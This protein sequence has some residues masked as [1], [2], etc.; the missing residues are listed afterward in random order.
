MIHRTRLPTTALA[1]LLA[2]ATLHLVWTLLGAPPQAWRATVG[3][4]L[5]FPVYALAAALAFGAAR[6]RRGPTRSA[7]AWIA[8]GILSWG[9]GQVVYTFIDLFTSESPFPSLADVGYLSLVPCFLIGVAHL[10]RRS[11]ERHQTFSFLLDIVIVVLAVG[12]VLWDVH[13][14]DAITSYAGQPFALAVALAY[15]VV[16]LVLCALLLALLLWRP[17]HLSLTQVGLLT[18]GLALFLGADL[19]YAYQTGEGTYEVG[20]PLDTLWVWGA[21]LFGAAA[22][23][24]GTSPTRATDLVDF[25]DEHGSASG[26]V[27]PNTAIIVTYALFAFLHL[28]TLAPHRDRV[29]PVLGWVTLLVL[30]RQVLALS[31][32][33]RLSRRLAYQARHDHLTGLLNRVS[34]RASL[35][36]AIEVARQQGHLA[37]V[38]F[39]DLDRMKLVNDSYGHR[40]GD[41]VLRV[42]AARLSEGAGADALVARAG[43]DEF[44]IIR[45]DVR[46]HHD[47]AEFNE[48]LLRALSQPIDALGHEVFLSASIGV[49]LCPRDTADPDTALR[50]ADVAMYEAKK[51]GK[52]TWRAYDHRYDDTAVEQL[53]LDTHLRLALTAEEFEL[54]YQPIV[55]LTDS[56]VLGF[57]ALLRWNSPVLGSVSPLKFIP[58][59]EAHG[60]IHALGAWALRRA[61]AQVRVW[62]EASPD[63]YVS[64][65]VSAHEFAR[66]SFVRDVRDALRSGGVEGGALVLELT[67]SALIDDLAGSVAKLDELHELGVRVAVD[68]FG[69]GYSSLSYLHRLRVQLLKIDR[70]FVQRLPDEGLPLV[71]AIITMAH[72]LGLDVVAEGVETHAQARTLDTL[73]CGLGQGYLF[74]RP[75]AEPMTE[76][77]LA[78]RPA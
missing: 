52:N 56:R 12:D 23:R 53:R 41:E 16:D 66:D 34:L 76:H 18:G 61:L 50:Y 21:V 24:A 5:F 31:D 62:R 17:R 36:H 58:V 3:N 51:N 59:A 74:G 60:L 1:V 15:P 72:S 55:R 43:G 33:Q 39:V 9:A 69:T 22:H 40:V 13:A 29:D 27:V 32:N 78:R 30:V 45:G 48:H 67:E 73:G 37:A 68:D 35:Q 38:L 63:L 10:P 19:G 71:R 57:E 28:G 77:D 25:A 20:G 46:C 49:A 26:V 64:V 2:L 14:H 42:M 8:A 7:W 4:L 65:N 54:H 6:R 70:S 44:V 47:L 75:R 11:L